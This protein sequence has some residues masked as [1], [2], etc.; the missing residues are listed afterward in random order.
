M[1]ASPWRKRVVGC[2]LRFSHKLID[3]NKARG[4]FWGAIKHFSK[5]RHPHNQRD[6]FSTLTYKRSLIK[7]NPRKMAWRRRNLC[8]INGLLRDD[9]S[10]RLGFFQAHLIGWPFV[11]HGDFFD[12]SR[13]KRREWWWWYKC[14][15]TTMKPSG[16]GTWCSKEIFMKNLNFEI[17]ENPFITYN[18]HCTV[19]C[20]LQPQLKSV[21]KCQKKKRQAKIV[22]WTFFA[23]FESSAVHST[24]RYLEG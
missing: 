14:M 15:T 6:I 1:P 17:S 8:F 4:K 13:V 9:I 22:K 12:K 19:L 16:G 24:S 7:W 5:S 10:I 2:R 18:I 20:V 11:H 3:L 21:K 23:D